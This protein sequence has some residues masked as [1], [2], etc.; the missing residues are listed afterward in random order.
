LPANIQAAIK[1]N[2][3]KTF[4]RLLGYATPLH[5]YIPEYVIYTILAIIFG[6]TNFTM[7]IPLLN[8]LFGIVKTEEA[9]KAIPPF[10]LTI[11][12]IITC[13]KFYFQQYIDAKG[14]F[15]GL[16]FVCVI[17]G[18][19]TLMANIFRYLSARVVVRLRMTILERLRN[20]L[21]ARL[22]EQSLSFYHNRQKGDIL[23]TMTN[24]VQEIENSVVTSVQVLLRDPFIIIVYFGALFYMSP[25]LT[26]FTIIFFPISG[27]FISYISKKLKQ[28]GYYSQEM[29]GKIMN[30]S[31]ESVGGIR[32]IQA[33]SGEGFMQRKFNAINR[34]FA[35]ISKSMFNQREMASPV[36]EILGIFVIVTLLLYGGSLVLNNVNNDSSLLTGA[37]FMTYLALYSQILQPAKNISSAVTTLQRGLVA[38]ER[39]FN[40]LDVPIT[41][42]EKP[43][44]KSVR[45]FNDAV[46][47]ENVSFKYDK[48]WVLKNINLP[49]RKGQMIALVGKS[50]SGKST[51][52]DLL[53]RFYDVVEGSIRI[54]GTDIRDIK[55][56][57]LRDLMGIVSQDA[58]LF[59][60]TIFNNIAFGQPNADKEAVIQAAKIAN[61]H[62][63]IAQMENG[64]D[65][66]IGD[67]GLKLSGGQRQRLTIARAVFKNP[68]ILILDE[69]TSALDTESEQ[70]VQ[71]A[72]DKLMQNRTSIVIAH[73]LSTIQHA[74]EIIV[75]DQGEIKER[76]THDVLLSQNG[77]YKKLVEMQEFK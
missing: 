16:V 43:N 71:S 2:G 45:D 32:I 50:G 57:D 51:M 58:I 61:A 44:A 8:T 74:S 52:A 70:L 65:T 49:V 64:Y 36:S 33:F 3:M 25:S 56:N 72:L 62:E 29:L 13:F 1:V 22:T 63:F 46:V 40:M 9:V 41:I 54:D 28:K 31:E 34:K 68:P 12:Y 42:T 20:N 55:L 21:Y 77:I 69:A 60:D 15:Y 59:N 4:K 66:N 39:I 38:G 27:F 67:R 19:C 24:D 14:P 47:Y 53:P 35:R 6:M 30:I 73:R 37:V 48:Q 17:I 76:G 11:D 18:V 26:L 75:M 10:S 23:S 7:L 5:H